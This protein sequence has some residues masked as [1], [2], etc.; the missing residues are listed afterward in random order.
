MRDFVR[1]PYVV[2][3]LFSHMRTANA[4]LLTTRSTAKPKLVPESPIPTKP[5]VT[6]YP[7]SINGKLGSLGVKTAL[8]SCAAHLSQQRW[9]EECKGRVEHNTGFRSLM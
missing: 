3:A 5:S 9:E 8:E 1:E 7:S 2:S 6:H 4:V